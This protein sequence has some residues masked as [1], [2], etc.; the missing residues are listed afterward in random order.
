M[1]R[2]R[3]FIET[4]LLLGL[5]LGL[6]YSSSQPYE[7][8]D[9]RGTISRYVDVNLLKEKWGHISFQYGRKEISVQESGVAGFI[10]FFIRKATHFLTFAL[11]TLM[12]YRVFSWFAS[13]Q[14]A[15]PW[16]GF[17]SVVCALLDEWHQTFTPDRTG[18]LTDVLLDTTGIGTMLLFIVFGHMLRVGRGK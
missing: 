17:L 14:A 9:M 13:F 18:M 8:Q 10:E 7:Q 2:L 11:I 12:F 15:L 1:K 6:F 4:V 16:S 5:M 3:L